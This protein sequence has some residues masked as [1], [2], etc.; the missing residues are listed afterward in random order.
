MKW[1]PARTI[2][3]PP[4]EGSVLVTPT[5][6]AG[7]SR[8]ALAT[9]CNPIFPNA[10]PRLWPSK[11]RLLSAASGTVGVD[12]DVASIVSQFSQYAKQLQP[13]MADTTQILLDAIDEDQRILFEGAQGA[14]LDVDHGTFP[15]VT[16]SNSSAAGISPGSGVPGTW[17]DEVIGVCKSY[18]TRVGGGPFPTEQ[19]NEKGQHIR[20]MGN[21]Y[22]TT[23]GRPRRCGWFDAVAVRYTSRLSGVTSIALTML[24][25]LSELE[26]IEVCVAYELAAKRVD[27]FPAHVNDL[28][29]L[30]PVYETVP[31]WQSDITKARSLDDLPT[32]AINYVHRLEQLIGRK[33]QF[34]SVGPDRAQTILVDQQVMLAEYLNARP[35]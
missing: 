4:C 13:M 2:L 17:I 31:G 33:V 6:S 28:R 29:N 21:E 9:C 14:L 12:L 26:T 11:S 18:S 35:V 1:F 16:S 22:G 23:T 15:F 24:D 10:S 32:A 34:I 27:Y 25:V 5:R 20:D 7:V 19:E 3:G 30:K 8:F